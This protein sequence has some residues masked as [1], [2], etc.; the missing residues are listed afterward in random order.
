MRGYLSVIIAGAF[1]VAVT[2][3]IFIHV[4]LV[5]AVI[6]GG[7]AIVSFFVWI[8]TTYNRP[9]NPDRIVPLYLLALAGQIIHTGEEYVA[10]FPGYL[11]GLFHLQNLDKNTFALGVLI[12]AAAIWVLA[13]Y[14]LLKKHPLA[15]YF[16]WFFLIGPGIAN[17]VAH[18]AFP[19]IAKSTYFPGLFT[20][21]IPTI[22]SLIIM[23]DVVK[24]IW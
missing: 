1:S 10:D 9:V 3:F 2:Y 22:L 24:D 21:L 12:I 8:F 7:S 16:L 20:V 11:T 17:G 19:F 4:G 13:G 6:I 23:R 18:I 5:P 15:N 14:G